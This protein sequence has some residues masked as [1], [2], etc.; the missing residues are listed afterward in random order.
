MLYYILYIIL[1]LTSYMKRKFIIKQYITV[2][3]Q[4]QLYIPQ[5]YN[6]SQ[7]YYISSTLIS[8]YLIQMVLE[9]M[10]YN[11]HFDICLHAHV[12]TCR[13]CVQIW[14]LGCVINYTLWFLYNKIVITYYLPCYHFMCVHMC[15]KVHLT[16][17]NIPWGKH[18][19]CF[20]DEKLMSLEVN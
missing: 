14:Q 15:V 7:L 3:F 11:I 5:V 10:N 20:R 12:N 8:C 17:Q 13:L 1:I 16:V 2:L 6:D 4:A 18:Q 19:L 9:E